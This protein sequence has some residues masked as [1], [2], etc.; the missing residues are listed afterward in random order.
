MSEELVTIKINDQEIQAKPGS[1]L[2]EA[3]DDAGIHIPRFCYHKKLSIAANCRMCL[4]EVERA[5]KPMP[6]CAT[7][8]NDGMKVWTRSEKA[9]SAQKDNMEFLLIN[10]PLDCPICDQGGECELQDLSVKSGGGSSNFKEIKRVVVD[11]DIGSLI[12]TEMTRCIQCTRCVRFGEEIAGLREMGALGRGDRMEIGTFVEQSLQSE[13]SGNIIDICPVG[14]LTAKPSRY[15]ARPWEVVQTPSI[16]S[17]DSVGSN[18]YVHSFRQHVV[19]TVAR[20]NEAVNE[21]W[22]SDRDRFSYEGVNAED[23]LLKPMIKQDGVWRDVEWSDALE[24][25]AERIKATDIS[26]LGALVSPRATLEEQYLLQK[27]LRACG[28]NNIDHRLRQSDFY[29]QGVAPIAPSLGISIAELEAQNAVLLIGSNVRQ[30]QPMINHR[31]RKA[32]LKGADIM[33]VNPRRYDFNYDVANQLVGNASEMLEQLAAIAVASGDIPSAVED[34]VKGVEVS[35]S[36]KA[37]AESLQQAD[38]AIILLGNIAVAH[39]QYSALR[40]LAMVI[41][42]NTGATIGSLVESANTAGA[43]MAGAVPHRQSAGQ[44]IEQEQAGKN[45]SEML[46]SKLKMF[47][48]LDV[49]PEFDCDDPQLALSAMNQAECVIAITPFASEAMKSYADILLPAS[50]ALETSG[51]FV[52]AEGTWQSFM[53]A[54]KLP[55]DARPTWKILRVLG[56][57]LNVSGFDYVSSEDVRDELKLEMD[58]IT[59]TDSNELMQIYQKHS[60]DSGVQRISEVSTYK[61]DS[62][63]RRAKALNVTDTESEVYMNSGDVDKLGLSASATVRLVQGTAEATAKIVIDDNVSENCVLVLGGTEL[64]SSLGSSFGAIAVSAV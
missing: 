10:H 44:A 43:W 46:T 37:I 52:N 25:V 3:A 41:A 15:K 19:R 31:L 11:K 55:E 16:A 47:I 58:G 56:N 2:I 63:V 60:V 53:G 57:A 39:P 12:A 51:T 49:E 54:S 30:E 29:D 8:V 27:M 36:I 26:Q 14:A 32:A 42:E 18:I 62:L 24:A 7:P 40:A 9:L 34:L 17:H 64:A 6:A 35:D 21:C 22:I 13:L 48:L 5:P 59:Q 20:E 38:K 33:T 4:V 45:S 50:T 61:S 1:M 28:V 23:R